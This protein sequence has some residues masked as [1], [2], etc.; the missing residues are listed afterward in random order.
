MMKQ[1]LLIAL[2]TIFT[3]TSFAQD[4]EVKRLKDESNKTIKNEPA[5]KEGWIKGGVFNLNLSQGAS[6]NWAAGPEQCVS[7]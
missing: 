5:Q 7:L 1:V 3:F 2:I 6:R 4:A